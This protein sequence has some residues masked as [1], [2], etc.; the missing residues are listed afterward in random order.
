MTHTAL[1]ARSFDH[2]DYAPFLTSIRDR[3]ASVVGGGA[4]LFTTDA[5][6]LFP[7]FLAA[8]PDAD[9][10]HYTCHACRRFVEAYG[11]LVAIAPDGRTVP[12]MWDVGAIP[13]GGLHAAVKA[14]VRLVARAKVTGVFLT[15]EAVWG[16]PVTGEWHHMAVTPPAP[17]VFRK[18]PLRTAF[19]A[20]AEKREDYGTLCRGLDEFP[21][22][23]VSNAVTILSAEALT[24]SEKFLGVAKWLADL[25]AAREGKNGPARDN[26]VWL[27]VA[28]AP[29]GFAHV[30]STMIGTLLEDLASGLP[31]D[32]VKAKFT[33]K[34][35]P[36]QY[37]RPQAPPSAGNIAQ[38]EKLIAGLRSAGSLERRFARLA[39]VRPLWTP[40]PPKTD[41]PTGGVFGHLRP[42]TETPT[43]VEVPA[44]TVTWE[45]FARTALAD[46]RLIEVSVPSR[47]AFYAF[48]TATH[49]DAPPILQ[50]D[51]EDARNPVSWYTYHGGSPASQ[52]NLS[53]GWRRCTAVVPFP[54]MWQPGHDHHGAGMLFA[55]EGA[56]DSRESGVA[57]F[58]ELLRS[59]YR[60]IRATIEAFS[61]STSL[62]G[63]EEAEVAGLAV[64][65]GTPSSLRVRVTPSTGGSVVYLIDRWD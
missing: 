37:Q 11:G 7:A 8:L 62:S 55:I 50:W 24:R 14:V 31:F 45:K 39:D 10:Q 61:A 21:A 29:A 6:D 64:R 43:A 58:P 33:A 52:W 41:P 26:V 35:H 42:K 15:S 40:A 28:T 34:M 44:V 56:R 12:A 9:R 18:T 46:A 2:D 27:A 38:A 23:V 20:S 1:D 48:V 30:R 19:Q 63:R 22:A 4:P 60:G 59:E 51:R 3:F 54:N 57:L 13:D 49:A 36:L 16:Q 65:K 47:G 32:D 53:P 25:H 17:M 5:A